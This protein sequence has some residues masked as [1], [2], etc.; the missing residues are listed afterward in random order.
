LGG[1]EFTILLEEISNDE[2]VMEVVRR[3]RTHFSTPIDLGG[4]QVMSG[5][6]IGIAFS[7]P[8]LSV[9]DLVRNADI[10]MYQAKAAGKH[11]HVVFDEHMREK[12]ELR[13]KLENDLRHA[14]END[15]LLVQYQPSYS[16]DQ[17][18]LVEVEALVRWQ[19]PE[20]GI[21]PPKE[22]I[23]IAEECGLIIAVGN[24]VMLEAAKF[25][26]EYNLRVP[27]AEQ[28]CVSVNLSAIQLR[29]DQ[30][31][32]S[33]KRVLVES[34]LRPDQLKLEITESMLMK[35]T[36]K[37]VAVMNE[38][39]KLGIKLAMDNFGTG[40]SSMSQL[41]DMPIDT[42]KIDRSFIS[43]LD[44][45]DSQDHAI[46]NAIINMAKSLRMSVTSEGIETDLQFGLLKDMGCDQVQGFLYSPAVDG[47]KLLRPTKKPRV[48]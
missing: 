30:L 11:Q 36:K 20:L 26:V 18:R 6:S 23:P 19:H 35:D 43:Q 37:V 39:K 15:E 48:A 22:F 4:N 41:K 5:G 17:S 28:I 38:L 8:Y 3:I 42:L 7:D 31:I 25:G 45:I 9:D 24:Y 10:A 27:K 33:I 12:V 32:P 44:S 21:I 34:G 46:V 1:D 13:L 16:V 29:S 14:L 40:Y 2:M 47:S